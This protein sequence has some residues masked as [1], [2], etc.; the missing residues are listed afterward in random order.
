MLP[1]LEEVDVDVTGAVCD[2]PDQLTSKTQEDGEITRFT[3]GGYVHGIC[4][5][6]NTIFTVKFGDSS[7]YMYISSTSVLIKKHV[8]NRMKFPQDLILMTHD[9][10]DKLII[11]DYVKKR[12]KCV[13]KVCRW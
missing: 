6:K 11:I 8:I 12:F 7:L 5:Y 4:V 2:K 1:C 3:V 13:C 10:G 9:D